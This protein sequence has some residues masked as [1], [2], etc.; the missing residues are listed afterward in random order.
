MA[1][2]TKAFISEFHIKT[3]NI[4][5]LP[6]RALFGP[7]MPDS[8]MFKKSCKVFAPEFRTVVSSDYLRLAVF[9]K[10]LLNKLCYLKRSDSVPHTISQQRPAK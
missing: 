5:V 6:G 10:E 1:Q 2:T 8:V 4:R 9:V 3:F 7:F